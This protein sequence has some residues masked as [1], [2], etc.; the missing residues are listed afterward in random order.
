MHPNF[1]FSRLIVRNLNE[2]A[3][4]YS[5]FDVARN[6]FVQNIHFENYYSFP[7]VYIW[8]TKLIDSFSKRR[9]GYSIIIFLIWIGQHWETVSQNM[10]FYRKNLHLINFNY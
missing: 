3:V 1:V 10:K 6:R 8:F 2:Q 9:V 7:I 5:I 4:S